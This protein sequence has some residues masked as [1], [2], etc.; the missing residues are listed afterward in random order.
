MTYHVNYGLIWGIC[1]PILGISISLIVYCL[2]RYQ[3]NKKRQNQNTVAVCYNPNSTQLPGQS[4][5]TIPQA[6]QPSVPYA[7]YPMQHYNQNYATQYTSEPTA[8]NSVP[9]PYIETDANGKK[10]KFDQFM[11]M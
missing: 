2:I 7:A 5:L 8:Y 11:S 6:N 4:N 1:S 9:P 10:Q 3:N